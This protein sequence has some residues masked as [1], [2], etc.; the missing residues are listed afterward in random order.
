[1]ASGGCA[2]HG[3]LVEH[4][5]QFLEVHL[6]CLEVRDL[7]WRS[8]EAAS[9]LLRHRRGI[10]KSELSVRSARV[11]QGRSLVRRVRRSWR[12][13]SAEEAT[14]EAALLRLLL[15]LHVEVVVDVSYVLQG[16]VSNIFC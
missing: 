15:S 1:M 12:L 14:K 4:L 10:R 11:A 5:L 16:A 9:A 3:S 13:A 2:Y 6:T 7:W 8:H